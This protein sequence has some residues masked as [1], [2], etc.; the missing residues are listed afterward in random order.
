MKV[1][2]EASLTG[3]EVILEYLLPQIKAKGVD[4][5][6]NDVK[7]QVENKAGQWVDVVPS[8]VKFIFTKE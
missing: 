1:K 3:D 6:E 7:V 5:T 8:K 4:G 2:T